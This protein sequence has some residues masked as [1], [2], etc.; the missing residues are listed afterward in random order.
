MTSAVAPFGRHARP[1]CG[2]HVLDLA[3]QLGVERQ[4]QVLAG[5]GALGLLQDD[6]L[7]E[8][9]LDDPPLAVA[10]AQDAS[11]GVL[12]AGEA[13]AVGADP[14]EHLRGQPLA[15]V[16][17]PRA[18]DELQA[19]DVELLDLRRLA[20]RAGC[21]R[22][23]RSRPSASSF[24]EQLGL[25]SCRAAARAGARPSIGFL[26]RYGV[27][28]TSSAGSETA[29]SM[30]LRSVIAPRRAGTLSTSTCCVLATACSDVALDGAEPGR[31]RRRDR[32]ATRGRSRTAARSAVR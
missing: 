10:A 23:R 31:A 6:R 20:C 28:A 27:A 12:Q 19:G 16:L 22:G 32:A 3:L 8:R 14:A 2:E 4:A 30:P 17:A 13:L 15:R 1:T 25:A 24:V 11:R 18:R 29:S 26:T 7:A 21:A 9:V 5:L